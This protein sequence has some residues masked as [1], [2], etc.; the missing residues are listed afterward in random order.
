MV[1]NEI[2]NF[3]KLVGIDDANFECKSREI[4]ISQGDVAENIINHAQANNCDLIVMGAKSGIF[5]KTSVGSIIKSVLSD[6]KIP[7]TIVPKTES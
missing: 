6:T 7:V 4:L 5:S 3:C 2:Q 1:R